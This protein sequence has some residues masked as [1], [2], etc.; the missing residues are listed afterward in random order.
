MFVLWLSLQ[1]MLQMQ[2]RDCSH[3]LIIHDSHSSMLTMLR[4]LWAG[5]I[6]ENRCNY[7][8]HIPLHTSS[9]FCLWLITSVPRI[10]ITQFRV[11][12]NCAHQERPNFEA[13]DANHFCEYTY[14]LRAKVSYFEYLRWKQL[15]LL[16]EPWIIS[17]LLRSGSLVYLVWEL[18]LT[19]ISNA[20]YSYI[21]KLNKSENI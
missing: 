9:V 8:P 13:S 5:W 20:A 10:T 6:A 3:V 21:Q 19:I 7:C 14:R 18:V 15:F 2:R 1:C 17:T 16:I 12:I 4:I 11:A